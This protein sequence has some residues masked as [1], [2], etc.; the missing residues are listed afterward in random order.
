MRGYG[1]YVHQGARDGSALRAVHSS[2]QGGA[3]HVRGRCL[4]A[5]ALNLAISASTSRVRP[6]RFDSRRS[7]AILR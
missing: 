7:D 5:A 2:R 6:I 1:P 3:Y 4:A